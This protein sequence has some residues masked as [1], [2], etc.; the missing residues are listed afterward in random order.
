MVNTELSSI[1]LPNAENQFGPRVNIACREFDFTLLFEDS[2]FVILPAV[3]FLILL[4]WRLQN[5]RKTPV[6]MTSYR[7][8]TLKIALLSVLF[9]LQLLF[10]GFRV[11]SHILYTRLSIASGVLGAVTT[12]VAAVHSLLEDQR[13]LQ[14]S[15]LLVLYFSA[16][17]VL[18]IPHLRSLWLIPSASIA[19]GLWTAIFI[20]MVMVVIVESL[21]KTRFF[22]AQYESATKEQT[23]GFWSRGFYIWVLPF[24]QVGYSKTIA[25]SDIPRVDSF[26]EEESSG[27]ELEAAWQRVGGR[28][29]MLHAAFR[30]NIW[31]I[32]FAIIPRLLQSVFNFCQPFLIERTVS[33]IGS[34]SEHGDERYG[35]GLVGAFVL[36]NLGYAVSYQ[37]LCRSLSFS[38]NK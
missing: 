33:Y 36:V 4:P 14:P 16:T 18:A 3:V 13:S 20:C 29:R 31:S 8:A 15:D 21:R 7:L 30:A 19:R 17:T 34:R 2:F 37:F 5:L 25:L 27:A 22:G 28:H 12:L 10:L 11:Q 38:S 1:C 35:Q 6:K 32:V 9:A 23:V 24:F 26:L